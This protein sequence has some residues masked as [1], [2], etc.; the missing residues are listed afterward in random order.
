MKAG[1]GSYVLF[2]LRI[3]T[4]CHSELLLFFS[5]HRLKKSPGNVKGMNCSHLSNFHVRVRNCRYSWLF[6]ALRPGQSWLYTIPHFFFQIK[7][8]LNMVYESLK[9]VPWSVNLYT[10][11]K[12]DLNFS[13]NS[14]KRGEL[15]AK[16][17]NS[18]KVKIQKV[19]SDR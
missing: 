19:Q 3:L 8:A 6:V 18:K 11:N 14:K 7:P 12:M 17:R 5:F 2:V 15:T 10:I 13:V 4:A 16:G 1:R 9:C